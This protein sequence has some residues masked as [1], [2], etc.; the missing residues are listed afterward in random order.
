MS[1]KEKLEKLNACRGAIEWVSDKDAKTAWETCERGDWMLWIA[2]R[3]GVNIKQLTLAKVKC[4]SLVKHLM[5][6]D[7]SLKALEVAEK[8]ALGEATIDELRAAA[9][10]ADAVAYAYAAY[11]AA[12]A[13]D[14]DAAAYAAAYAAYAAV[15]AAA[16]AADGAYVVRSDILLKAANICREVISFDDLKWGDE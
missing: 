11:A 13:A 4:A 14:A 15:D 7:R 3:Q 1:V 6:D 12:D 5:K 16:Y 9:H 8:F 10:A 2:K